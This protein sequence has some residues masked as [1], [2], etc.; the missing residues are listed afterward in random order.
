MKKWKCK[1]HNQEEWDCVKV[2]KDEY[3]HV[4]R[5][6]AFETDMTLDKALVFKGWVIPDNEHITITKKNHLGY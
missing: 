2:G 4:K 3:Y 1:E 6:K 5:N